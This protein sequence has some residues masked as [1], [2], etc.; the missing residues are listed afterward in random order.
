MRGD[1]KQKRRELLY[2][3]MRKLINNEQGFSLM[4]LLVATSIFVIIALASLSIY[5][6]TLRA[7]QKSLA[8]TRV[9][10]EAQ[11]IMQVL[12][13]KIRTSHVNYD[14]SG[15]TKPLVNP[16]DKLA[17]T[18]LTGDTYV[19]KKIDNYVAVSVNGSA[20]KNIS[21]ANV[22]ITD[23]K[24]YINPIT[25]PF[26]TLDEPPSSVPYVTIVLTLLSTKAQQSSTL[27]IQ[28]TL[29]QRSGVEAE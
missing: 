16:E 23:L 10:Q 17:L 8:L 20:D 29:P 6:A 1:D 21:A 15:Y 2:F 4:E 11:L 19:F 27:T 25:N 22:S 24:F 3:L 7:S 28:E 18:D 12:A 14:Y 13:K 26:I 5:S 9:Q